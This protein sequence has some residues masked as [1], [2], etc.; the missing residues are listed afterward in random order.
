MDPSPH[1][2]PVNVAARAGDLDALNAALDAGAVPG[3]WTIAACAAR[4]DRETIERLRARA[5]SCPWDEKACTEA[6]AC[7]HAT[8]V[9]WLVEEGCPTSSWTSA[10]S[11]RTG[12]LELLKWLRARGVDW[13][14]ATCAGAAFNGHLDVLMWA[15]EHGC[16]WDWRTVANA[17]EHGYLRCLTYALD[18]N[19]QLPQGDAMAELLEKVHRRSREEGGGTYAEILKLI[20]PKDP[21]V[22]D[23]QAIM[24]FI[25]EHA[26]NAPEGE[27]LET[28]TR[29]QRLFNRLKGIAKPAGEENRHDRAQRRNRRRLRELLNEVAD[30]NELR[31][32]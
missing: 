4:G 1:D 21:H 15:R 19:C 16:E 13:D 29:A 32:L 20:D 14:A 22:D 26:T 18:R 30:E 2:A 11:G 3:E 8:L 12:E 25:D 23:L 5:P 9:R 7:G 24:S 17:A 10:I 31:P 27:Y 28:A 6:I